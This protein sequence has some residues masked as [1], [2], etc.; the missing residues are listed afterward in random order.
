MAFLPSR[1]AWPLESFSLCASPW[2]SQALHRST[3]AS[4]SWC[5]W[6][7]R[8]Q[9]EWMGKVAEGWARTSCMLLKPV[10][11]CGWRSRNLPPTS[12]GLC[13]S[14]WAEPWGIRWT[15]SK[16]RKGKPPCHGQETEV[17]WREIR[18]MYDIWPLASRTQGKV[19]EDMTDFQAV[20]PTGRLL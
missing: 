16:K 9:R 6:R 4:T 8:K 19:S 10:L 5:E 1:F 3:A 12:L 7:L 14:L 13:F 18:Q 2:V 20:E 15:G 17:C 11:T